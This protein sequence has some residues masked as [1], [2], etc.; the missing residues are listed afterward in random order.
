[1]TIEN[2]STYETLLNNCL[3]PYKSEAKYCLSRKWSIETNFCDGL[4]R[5]S[6]SLTEFI[7]DKIPKRYDLLVVEINNPSIANDIVLLA[8]FLN[9]LLL[10]LRERDVLAS[11]PLIKNIETLSWDF[12]FNDTKFFLPVFA[13]LY[14]QR[15]ARQ[16]FVKDT[17]FIQFQHDLAFSW[18]G[19]SKNS[20][21]REEIS[22]DVRSVFE[23]GGRP[24]DHKLIDGTPKAIR[25]IKPKRLGEEPVLWWK[26]EKYESEN[27]L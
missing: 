11:S 19:I 18:R 10:G 2:V 3:C 12:V 26:S 7:Q 23:K 21:N 25:Y 27:L 16:S 13:P 17:I 1:M 22:E 20:P 9:A 5:V 24:Y 6:E 8:K 14:H 4:S 15:H